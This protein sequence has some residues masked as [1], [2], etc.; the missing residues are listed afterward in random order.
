LNE[1]FP[2]EV[3][4]AAGGGD[5]VFEEPKLKVK[6]VGDFEASF[7]PTV[8]D[9]DRLDERFRLPE[10][11]WTETLPRY[12]DWGFAVFKLKSQHQR[13]HPIALTFPRRDPEKLFFPTLHIHDGEFHDEADFDHALYC[14]ISDGIR[15]NMMPWQ[16]SA[17]PAGV[18]ML[19]TTT[20]ILDHQAHVYRHFVSGMRKNADIL[21]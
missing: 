12:S 3:L 21:V 11:I 1:G 10:T 15:R 19:P 8:A 6:D 5:V 4:H 13:V 14:Q 2:K 7:V 20:G 16:E 17:K 18:Y 9:F